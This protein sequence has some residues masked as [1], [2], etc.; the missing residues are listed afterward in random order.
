[1]YRTPLEEDLR[2]DTAGTFKRLMVSLCTGNRDESMSVNH[3]A[4]R[5]DAQALL[6]AGE[7]RFGTDES[8]FNMVLCQRNYAQL[9][10]IFEEYHRVTGHDIED[11]IKNEFSG[12]AEDGLLAVVRAVRN[13]PGFYAKKLHESMKGF[14]TNDRQLIRLVATRCEVDMGEIKQ[15]YSAKYGKSLAEA[16]KV[17]IR[18]CVSV[19]RD[20]LFVFFFAGRHV[21]GLQKVFAGSHRRVLITS[22]FTASSKTNFVS[23]R[24][25]L[26]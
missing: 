21:R 24:L 19:V 18:K 10:T 17:F 4:A 6:A 12:D 26:I 15:Q 22:L 9:R 20:R 25:L 1:M 7:L 11:A 8:T 5:A 3:D 14:G 13:K 23:L 2:G 16:I